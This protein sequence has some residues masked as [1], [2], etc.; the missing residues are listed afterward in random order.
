[1]SVCSTVVAWNGEEPFHLTVDEFAV[2]LAPGMFIP[3]FR[4][5]IIFE[6]PWAA[7]VLVLPPD[8]VIVVD[9][10]G[11]RHPTVR[12]I[13]SVLTPGDAGSMRPLS[14]LSLSLGEAVYTAESPSAHTRTGSVEAAA[15]AGGTSYE[16]YS[17]GHDA[18]CCCSGR[19]RAYAG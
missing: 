16:E 8:G 4:F 2:N 1:M 15:D 13:P 6:Y 11:L 12:S 5:S 17:S 10:L 7:M 3:G 9:L 14:D 18:D 19:D